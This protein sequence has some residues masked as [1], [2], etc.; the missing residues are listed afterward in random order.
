MEQNTLGDILKKEGIKI[1]DLVKAS[2]FSYSHVHNI[3]S[4]R[5]KSSE[6]MQFALIKHLNNLTGKKYS[7]E[8]VFFTKKS[9]A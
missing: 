2:G 6:T 8:D 1:I 4:N 3:I 5:T 7:R 9:I